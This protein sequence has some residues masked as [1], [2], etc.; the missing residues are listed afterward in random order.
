MFLFDFERWDTTWGIILAP[1]GGLDKGRSPWG[2]PGGRAQRG[3]SEAEEP[4][5]AK[6]PRGG[7]GLAI[8]EKVGQ[9][10]TALESC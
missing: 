4:A 7:E 9:F 6:P 3:R 10:S 2:M 8:G 5:G 1:F